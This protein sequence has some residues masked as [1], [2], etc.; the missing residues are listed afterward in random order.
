MHLSNINISNLMLTFRK[1]V[2]LLIIFFFSAKLL[3]QT[4][5]ERKRR[6][7][8]R[9]ILARTALL[10]VS[11]GQRPFRPGLRPPGLPE[12]LRASTVHFSRRRCHEPESERHAFSTCPIRLARFR[13][14]ARFRRLQMSF[15][16]NWKFMFST[17]STPQSE[18]KIKNLNDTKKIWQLIFCSH[19]FM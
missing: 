9:A 16:V 7:D 3:L 6:Y 4:M 12:L 15:H 13:G 8:G 11:I 2:E 19:K 5:R 14:R 18:Y 17:L 1:F 10:I